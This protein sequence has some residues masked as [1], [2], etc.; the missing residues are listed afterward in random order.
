[1]ME[2]SM[3]VSYTH[4]PVL[5]HLLHVL[6]ASGEQ[7]PDCLHLVGAHL[8]FYAR[9]RYPEMCIR[10]RYK[11]LLCLSSTVGGTLIEKALAILYL[12]QFL[13]GT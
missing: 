13:G 8:A 10:D 9:R 5:F 4:L 3:T 7:H 11:S 1:M 12:V 2:R 6:V